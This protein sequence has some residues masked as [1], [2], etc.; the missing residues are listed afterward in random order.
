MRSSYQKK[1]IYIYIY[2][3]EC[4]IF[5]SISSQHLFCFI[6]IILQISSSLNI[7]LE[8]ELQICLHTTNVKN[9]VSDMP[10]CRDGTTFGLGGPRFLKKNIIILYNNFYIC[11]LILAILFY[12]ITFCFSLTIS[13]ILLKVMSYSKAFL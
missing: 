2:I 9:D 6:Y 8:L 3:Y 7:S 10:K 13:L 5:E 12:K 11:V 4:E 1:N